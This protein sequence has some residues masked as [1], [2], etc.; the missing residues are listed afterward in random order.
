M[1]FYHA[2]MPLATAG[3]TWQRDLTRDTGNLMVI[4]VV[5]EALEQII[6]Y[7]AVRQ[8]EYTLERGKNSP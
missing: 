7:F 4:V 1:N 8:V 6:S 2:S 5:Q 3:K